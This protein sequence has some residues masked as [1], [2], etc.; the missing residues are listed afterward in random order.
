LAVLSSAA[1]GQSPL[2]VL[3]TFVEA[4]WE[5]HRLYKVGV[6]FSPFLD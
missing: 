1:D 5:P 6:A 3:A 4:A 2:T